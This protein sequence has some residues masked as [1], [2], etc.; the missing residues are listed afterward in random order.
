MSDFY[1]KPEQPR[2]VLLAG[3]VTYWIARERDG[4]SAADSFG[5]AGEAIRALVT[6]LSEGEARA[7]AHDVI[8]WTY[9]PDG[10]RFAESIS[11]EERDAAEKRYIAWADGGEFGEITCAVR[12]SGS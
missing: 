10:L 5:A 12:V 7:I 4:E 11:N 6:S 8:N 9:S 1:E 3:Y 2:D